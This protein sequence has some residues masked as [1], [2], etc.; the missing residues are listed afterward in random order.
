MAA[1]RRRSLLKLDVA[2][3]HRVQ[4]FWASQVNLIVQASSVSNERIDLWHCH[5]DQRDEIEVPC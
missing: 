1:T 4:I 5:V 3:L 2:D